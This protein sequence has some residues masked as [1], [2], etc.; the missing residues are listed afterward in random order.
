MGNPDNKF[1]RFFKRIAKTLRRLRKDPLNR[2]WATLL[3]EKAAPR[4]GDVEPDALA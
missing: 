4:G 3:A 2:G 1:R